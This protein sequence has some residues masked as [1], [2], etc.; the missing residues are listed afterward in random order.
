MNLKYC[1]LIVQVK[2]YS[3][4]PQEIEYPYKTDYIEKIDKMTYQYTNKFD[5]FNKNKKEILENLNKNKEKYNLLFDVTDIELLD[6]IINKE[7]RPVIPLFQE[8]FME[9]RKEGQNQTYKIKIDDLLLKM[10]VEK[11]YLLYQLDKKC[12][13]EGNYESIFK[14][15]APPILEKLETEFFISPKELME[16]LAS[17]KRKGRF[18]QIARFLL[19]IKENMTLEN[20]K[21]TI[22]QYEK[23]R[24]DTEEI[25]VR[26]RKEWLPYVDK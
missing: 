21:K 26:V 9:K 10:M 14:N 13:M 6:I 5:F 4:T 19:N 2:A 16:I 20:F 3:I 17:W 12:V 24:I 1:S 18:F 11:I 25:N 22:S 7:E 8:I 23:R 15:F